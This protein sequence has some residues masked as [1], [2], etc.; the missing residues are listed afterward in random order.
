MAHNISA[1]KDW[2]SIALARQTEIKNSIP[3]AHRLSP[4]IFDT[5]QDRRNLINVPETCGILTQR[6][7]EIT[8]LS[9]VNLL[10]DIK[11]RVYTAFEV[12]TAFCKRTSIAHQ[13]ASTNRI[14]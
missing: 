12:T 13:L 6:E 10:K 3:E 14:L 7:I 5:L 8:S 9:A 4:A 11:N 2:R 1:G